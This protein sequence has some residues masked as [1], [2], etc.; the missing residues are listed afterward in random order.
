M[1][2]SGRKSFSSGWNLLFE[3]SD[4]VRDTVNVFIPARPVTQPLKVS[5]VLRKM[6]ALLLA[7]GQPLSHEHNVLFPVSPK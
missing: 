5:G 7:E 1:F 2:L 6:P 3:Q 4:K